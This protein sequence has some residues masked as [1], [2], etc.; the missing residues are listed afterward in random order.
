MRLEAFCGRWSLARRIEDLRAGQ[1]GTLHGEA[2]FEPAPGGLAYREEGVLHLGGARFASSRSYLW[3]ESGFN[4]I[5]VRF[6][7]G[8]FFHRF[9]SDEVR[10]AAV[11]D[12]GDDQYR[13][14]YDFR[15][16]PRWRAEWRVVG[17]RKDYGISSEY[18]PAGQDGENAA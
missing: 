3:L 14:R 6:A 8:R 1:S 15:R 12:C 17:P 4:V 13:V 2:R 11:H 9:C 5:E 16:W 18:R 10:P 7:D